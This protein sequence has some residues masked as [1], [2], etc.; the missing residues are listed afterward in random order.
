MPLSFIWE[1]IIAAWNYRGARELVPAHLGIFESTPVVN[2]EFIG[3]V[4]RGQCDYVRCD[5]QRLT[6]DGVRVKVR[7]R[8]AKPGEGKEEKEVR[9]QCRP[10][11]RLVMLTYN[12]DQGRCRGPGYWLQEA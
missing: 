1:K 8:E 7:G 5:I 10:D 9:L 12:A 6:K 3:Q 11:G 2:D 4:K